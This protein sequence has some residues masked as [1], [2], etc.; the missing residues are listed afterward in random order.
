VAGINPQG[1]NSFLNNVK[2]FRWRVQYFS[3]RYVLELESKNVQSSSVRTIVNLYQH[4]PSASGKC[5]HNP[6]LKRECTKTTTEKD[7]YADLPLR[8]VIMNVCRQMCSE[9]AKTCGAPGA[10]RSMNA[11]FQGWASPW[12]RPPFVSYSWDSIWKIH[13]RKNIKERTDRI[14]I[15]DLAK[16]EGKEQEKQEEE[17]VG[18]KTPELLPL[19]VEDNASYHSQMLNKTNSKKAAIQDWLNTNNI[20]NEEEMLKAEVLEIVTNSRKEKEYIIDT[21]LTQHGHKVWRLPPYHCQFNP[22]ELIWGIFKQ[23]YGS[24]IGR[25]GYG[26]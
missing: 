24:H 13:K 8:P 17:A 21:L 16:E 26:D 2:Q 7:C 18:T 1:Y 5:A 22:I 4:L 15:I 19:E 3:L 6:C 11:F 10:P 14:D 23:Y 20:P 25:D 12:E 9:V